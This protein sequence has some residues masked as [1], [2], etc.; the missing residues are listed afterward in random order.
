MWNGAQ[1]FQMNFDYNWDNRTEIPQISDHLFSL[2]IFANS[3]EIQIR[4]TD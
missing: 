4:K 3:Q 2:R 1:E